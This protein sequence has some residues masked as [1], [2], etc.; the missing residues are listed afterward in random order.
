MPVFWVELELETYVKL[1]QR[2]NAKTADDA[3]RTFVNRIGKWESTMP[4][5]QP[6]CSITH[7][8]FPNT[9]YSGDDIHIEVET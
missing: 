5:V 7:S 9:D 1:S 8:V 3:R 4:R 6:E 2:I